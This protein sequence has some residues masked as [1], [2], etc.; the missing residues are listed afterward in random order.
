MLWVVKPLTLS[1]RVRLPQE[2]LLVFPSSALRQWGLE[3]VLIGLEGK[4]CTGCFCTG[5]VFLEPGK[6]GFQPT[7]AASQGVLE[8]VI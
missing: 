3:K 7:L 5:H 8:T 6:H 4:L 1:D 2:A